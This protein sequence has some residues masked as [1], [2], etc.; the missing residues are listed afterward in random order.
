MSCPSVNSIFSDIVKP[1]CMIAAPESCVWTM[2]GLIG[3]PTS[4]T[5]TSRV[6]RNC[7]VSV[8]TSTSAPLPPI[9][10]NGVAL[11]VCPVFGSG[12]T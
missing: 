2:R 7:P 1:N 8:S 3:V 9:I 12:V 5:L 10:Q 4:A 6:T 11:G